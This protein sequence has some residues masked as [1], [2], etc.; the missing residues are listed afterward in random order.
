MPPLIILGSL[1][2]PLSIET[3][4]YLNIPENFRICLLCDEDEIET[5]VHFLLYCSKYATE[6]QRFMVKVFSEFPQFDNLAAD[7]KLVVLM[8][9]KL[10]KLTASFIWECLEIRRHTLYTSS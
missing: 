6:R 1:I 5:E 8:T 4:R 10:I 7:E 2:L 3:G 9:E